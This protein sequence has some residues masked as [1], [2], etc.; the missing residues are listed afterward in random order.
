MKF[1]ELKDEKRV[2]DGVICISDAC[3]S[4][5]TG[6]MYE[7][8]GEFCSE[9]ECGLPPEQVKVEVLEEINMIRIKYNQKKIEE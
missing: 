4:V 2:R 7:V 8:E 9:C 3:I 1:E 6:E 5:G